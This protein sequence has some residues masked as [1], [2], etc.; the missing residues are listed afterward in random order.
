MTRPA[1]VQPGF[2]TLRLGIEGNP[3]R[4][5]PAWT[6]LAGVILAGEAT[7]SGLREA[8]PRLLVALLLVEPL[9]GA[10]WGQLSAF[11]GQTE[12]PRPIHSLPPLPYARPQ[13]PLTALWQRL[14]GE[15]GDIWGRYAWLAL[16]LAVMAAAALGAQ[17]LLATV[18]LTI[19]ATL[20]VFVDRGLPALARGLAALAA[21]TLPGWLGF[22]LFA[23][24]GTSLWP[25]PADRWVWFVLL[26]F[27]L[28]RFA[29]D[30]AEDG[31]RRGWPALASLVTG[32]AMALGVSLMAGGLVAIL[33]LLPLWLLPP[34]R[35]HGWQW[36]ALVVSVWLL[37]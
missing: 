33:L 7:G 37:V 24:A 17:A 3:L 8:A 31:G 29:R 32:A 18:A 35:W 30:Q 36:L 26:A 2:L 5:A 15:R 6:L 19:L 12:K 10:L 20:A 9:W 27:S 34:T 23:G 16:L 28:L 21:V 14:R 13:A 22:H 1:S 11:T 25:Q 4:L